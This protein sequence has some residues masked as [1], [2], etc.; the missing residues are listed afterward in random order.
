MALDTVGRY[1]RCFATVLPLFGKSDKDA[2]AIRKRKTQEYI[3]N[4]D[5]PRADPVRP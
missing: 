2:D 4:S 1:C 3:H 5:K